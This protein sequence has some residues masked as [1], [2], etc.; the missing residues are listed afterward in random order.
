[1][2]T[3]ELNS[4]SLG[5]GDDPIVKDLDLTITD[6]EMVSLLGPSGAGK[7]TILKAVA[8]LLPPLSGDIRIDGKSVREQPAEHRD[9]VLV[10]Q[11]P[12][13]FPFMNVEQN[14]GFGLRMR[15]SI[16]STEKTRIQEILRLTQLDGLE[17]RKTGQLSG[18]QQQRV[19]LARAIVLKPSLLLLDEPF[20]NLDANLRQ[21]MR[22]LVRQIRSETQITMLFVTHD[23]TEALM[24]SDKV[25]LLLDGRMRQFGTPQELFHQP[26]DPDVARFFGAVNFFHGVVRGDLFL[27]ELYQCPLPRHLDSGTNLSAT[28]RPEDV[29]ISLNGDR[30]RGHQVDAT[31]RRTNFEGMTTRVWMSS[32]NHDIVA[33]HP[34][35][36]FLPGQKVHVHFP[37]DKVRLFIPDNE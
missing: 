19:S 34:E 21:D 11:Q 25:G 27:S 12:L 17:K 9:A 15:G 28:I 23:Q 13:L 20:S 32:R 18:G 8:G 26:A 2:G 22:D 30:G 33:L 35:Q 4:L 10:F 29:V 7:T 5:Y 3:L 36:H 16:T 24:M 1:M 14:V 37:P 31:V 6:G